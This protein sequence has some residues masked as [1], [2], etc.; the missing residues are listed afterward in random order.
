VERGYDSRDVRAQVF[1]KPGDGLAEAEAYALLFAAAPDLLQAC[2]LTL[3]DISGVREMNPG[4]QNS[5]YVSAVDAI[6]NRVTKRL[7]EAIEKARGGT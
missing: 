1:N 5:E 4:D 2:L 7:R 3:A 6:E